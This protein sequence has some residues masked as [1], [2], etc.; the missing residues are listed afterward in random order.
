MF[1]VKL[2]AEPDLL[3]AMRSLQLKVGI[4]EHV[5]LLKPQGLDGFPELC[6]V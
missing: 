1:L 5:L 4:S 6:R 2:P 3:L